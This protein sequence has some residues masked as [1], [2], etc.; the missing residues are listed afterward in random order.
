MSR[1]NKF[2]HERGR[3]ALV[4]WRDGIAGLAPIAEDAAAWTLDRAGRAWWVDGTLHAFR[5][6]EGGGAPVS[7][8]DVPGRDPVSVHPLPSGNGAWIALADRPCVPAPPPASAGAALVA[9]LSRGGCPR[10]VLAGAGPVP[11]EVKGLRR[12]V[13]PPEGWP[14][15]LFGPVEG[16]PAFVAAGDPADPVTVEDGGL[17]GTAFSPDGRR[18]AARLD[19]DGGEAIVLVDVASGTTSVLAEQA[20]EALLSWHGDAVVYAWRNRWWRGDPRN[21][22]YRVRPDEPTNSQT[23]R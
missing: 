12:I 21:G 17:L 15:V 23:P 9:A 2:A 18:V 10:L 1:T 8:G 6:P 14:V 7:L 11:P 3:R 4:R 19:R 13:A 22:L 20:P 5:E 16:R